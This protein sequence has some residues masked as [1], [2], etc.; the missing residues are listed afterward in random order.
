MRNKFN[1][2]VDDLLY[3]VDYDEYDDENEGREL[4][5][6][7]TGPMDGYKGITVVIEEGHAVDGVRLLLKRYPWV[8]ADW[9]ITNQRFRCPDKV[10]A[11]VKCHVEDDYDENVG[12]KLAVQRLNRTIVRNREAAVK[13]FED[14]IRNILKN[15]AAK[16]VM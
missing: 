12:E 15:P 3:D 9:L 1:D 7:H 16:K 10:V 8:D 13:I 2:M 14:Y 11:K 5:I 4:I 6:R